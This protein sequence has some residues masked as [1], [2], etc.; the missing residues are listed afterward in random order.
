MISLYR[1]P[2]GQYGYN[3]HIINLPQD[4]ESFVNRLPRHP[5]DLDIIVVRQQNSSESHHD[6]R[7]R[8]SKV[9]GVLQW[10]LKGQ[11]DD[12][13]HLIFSNL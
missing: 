11:C 13:S 10:L 9:V 3:G 6:F 7:V 5:N 12:G 4:V 2:H 1:L 8:R